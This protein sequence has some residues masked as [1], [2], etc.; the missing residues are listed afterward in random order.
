M[1]PPRKLASA[2]RAARAYFFF[3]GR[4]VSADAAAVFAA[5]DDLGLLRT[6]PAAEAAFLDVTSLL[7][8]FAMIQTPCSVM[9]GAAYAAGRSAG[10][11]VGPR[12]ASRKVCA[13]RENN[14]RRDSEELSP[15]PPF[16][17]A[18]TV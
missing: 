4:W 14:C 13:V 17:L 15:P 7:V 12:D 18:P 5:L 9:D 8:P 3:P 6:L 11:P 2:E 10:S 16:P 1:S